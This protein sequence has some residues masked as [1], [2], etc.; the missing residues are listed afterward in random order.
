M[1]EISKEI[2]KQTESVAVEVYKDAVRPVIKPIGEILGFLPRT[3]KLTFSGWEKWL[4]NGE[5]S[6]K[7][8]TEMIADRELS[9]PISPCMTEEQVEWGVKCV[10]EFK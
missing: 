1:E 9:L 2:L 4:I 10:N 5:E 7:L 3:L 8:I 6:L